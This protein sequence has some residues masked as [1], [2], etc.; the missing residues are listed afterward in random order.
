M[1]LFKQSEAFLW[2]L[3]SDLIPGDT[4]T[5]CT[6]KQ[7][8]WLKVMDDSPTQNEFLH[9]S[10]FSFFLSLFAFTA[11]TSLRRDLN[12]TPSDRMRRASSVMTK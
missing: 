2:S 10:G 1:E 11:D 12:E 8:L 3:I 9:T 6:E 7:N 4:D 5:M